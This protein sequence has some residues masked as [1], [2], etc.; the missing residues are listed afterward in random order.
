MVKALVIMSPQTAI[1]AD[2]V[3][4]G[5]NSYFGPGPCKY[6][7]KSGGPAQVVNMEEDGGLAP[8]CSEHRLGKLK[9]RPDYAESEWGEK[10]VCQCLMGFWITPE[11][12]N[13]WA[14][15]EEKCYG[16]E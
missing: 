11:E 2:A 7:D 13:D 9:N 6:R 4:I 14:E 3:C 15:P 16:Q 12:D 8:A 10:I 1:P 5:I